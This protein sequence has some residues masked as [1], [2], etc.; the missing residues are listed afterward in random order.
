M[1]VFILQQFWVFSEIGFG[2]GLN[3]PKSGN[4][5]KKRCT[6]IY[7]STRQTHTSGSNDV[8]YVLGRD[9]LLRIS[10]SRGKGYIFFVFC[11]SRV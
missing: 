11:T 6:S 9:A 2:R 5:E 8:G 4:A 3:L 7:R 10:L 1:G